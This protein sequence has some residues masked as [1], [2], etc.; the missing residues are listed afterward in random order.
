MNAG[1]L[2]SEQMLDNIIF[3]Y[4]LKGHKG[5]LGCEKL[6]GQQIR[7]VFPNGKKDKNLSS[8]GRVISG[9]RRE[10]QRSFWTGDQK[11]SGEPE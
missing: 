4:I 5:G 11:Q 3:Q 9:E 8:T 7:K 6:R 10:R 2:A 1:S